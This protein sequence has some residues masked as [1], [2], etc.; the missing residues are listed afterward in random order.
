MLNWS[1]TLSKELGKHNITVNNVLP[2]YTDTQR[3]NE[4]INQV[5]EKFQITKTQYSQKLIDQ[6]PLG[7]F[8]RPQEIAAVASFLLSPEASFISGASIPVDGGWTPCP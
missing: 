6:I 1:K 3:L 7:R 2:G 4:V 8:G 5:S